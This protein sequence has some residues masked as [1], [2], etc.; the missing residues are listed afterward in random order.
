MVSNILMCPCTDEIIRIGP[1]ALYIPDLAN[2]IAEYAHT[3]SVR[4]YYELCQSEYIFIGDSN[5]C[6]DYARYIGRGPPRQVGL[7]PR[8]DPMN[9]CE[10]Q[11]QILMIRISNTLD[12]N[13]LQLR[14]PFWES[15]TEQFDCAN[16]ELLWQK[17]IREDIKLSKI[18]QCTS[19]IEFNIACD[20][21][22]NRMSQY[23]YA[24]PR[25]VVCHNM[26]EPIDASIVPY[27]PMYRE[28]GDIDESR[29]VYLY[30]A[31]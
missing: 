22:L 28:R 17:I 1:V 30:G 16:R 25:N 19:P 18:Q 20:N 29:W 13:V 27:P 3:F 5:R 9:Q 7:L 24:R 11:I 14:S 6:N 26:T 15:I 31:D 10:I 12:V 21:I 8:I 2:I 23:L 4:E